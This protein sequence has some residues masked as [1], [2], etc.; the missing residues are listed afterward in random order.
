MTQFL[1][2]QVPFST[3]LAEPDED[4]DPPAGGVRVYRGRR[5]EEL[6]PQIRAELGP[7]AIIVRERQG[8]MGGIGGFFAQRCVEVEA[9]VAQ[10]VDVY[11]DDEDED[12][13]DDLD[14][15][16]GVDSAPTPDLLA[17]LTAPPFDEPSFATQLETAAQ[18]DADDWAPAVPDAPGTAAPDFIAFDELDA[19]FTA[20]R[21]EPAPQDPPGEPLPRWLE[22]SEPAGSSVAA[23]PVPGPAT[24]IELR[25]RLVR[26]GMSSTRAEQLIAAAQLRAGRSAGDGEL[27]R[28]LALCITAALPAPVPLP[29]D[30]GAFAVVGTTDADMTRC[31]AALAGAHARVGLVGVSVT[32]IGAPGGEG[33]LARMLAGE[34]V[35]VLA[36]MRPRELGLAVAEARE[37]GLVVIDTPGADPADA[38]TLDVLAEALAPFALDGVY[39]TVPANLSPRAAA[40]L[41]SGF[42]VL[43]VGALIATSLDAGQALG[44]LAELSI[45]TG[46]PLSYTETEINGRTAI[47]TARREQLVERILR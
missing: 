14:E 33:E 5:L 39:L 17:A 2:T 10:R 13:E 1:R 40:E 12:V 7:D 41:V 38:S 29:V 22:M 4:L 11:D 47:V 6:V 31:V 43:S 25:E 35:E 42:S 36:S 15:L 3:G 45:E 30:G 24:A 8:V 34:R 28:A 26:S 23:M 9:T 27:E 32:R 44:M 37:R 18:D 16:V 46:L 20:D 19:A 21:F